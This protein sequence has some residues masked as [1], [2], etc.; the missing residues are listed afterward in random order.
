M[1]P[2]IQQLN[3][4]VRKR[5]ESCVSSA[6]SRPDA[7]N[8]AT[9]IPIR[10]QPVMFTNR[11]ASGKSPLYH[12]DASTPARKRRTL[13]AAPPMATKMICLIIWN[14]LRKNEDGPSF[15]Y[16]YRN[17]NL[18]QSTRKSRKTKLNAPCTK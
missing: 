2:G 12:F 4:F 3:V 11:V 1:L 10:K 13:P 5:R 15:Y 6:K 9:R 14:I 8:C 16:Q 17:F 7:G 18:W